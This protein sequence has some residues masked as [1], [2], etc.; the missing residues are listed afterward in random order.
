VNSV[1]GLF[2]SDDQGDNWIRNND[3]E[4]EWARNYT[5]LA[6][7]P[8]IYDRVYIGLDGRGIVYGDIK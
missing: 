1:E 3:E 5:D 4:T 8:R 7:D 6:G 2:R